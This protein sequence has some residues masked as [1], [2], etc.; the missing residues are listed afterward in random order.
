MSRARRL[1]L[2]TAAGAGLLALASPLASPRTLD[3]IH[4]ARLRR[5]GRATVPDRLAEHGAAVRARLEP[6]FAAAGVAFAPGAVLLVAFKQERRL[7]LLNSRY[8]LALRVGYPNEHDRAV[9]RAE[10]RERLGGDIMIPGGSASVGCLALGDEAAE[11]L[12]VLAALAGIEKVEVLISPVGF[13]TA[14]PPAASAGPPWVAE[15]YEGLR[16]RLRGLSSRQ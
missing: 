16:D 11:D 13:R 3:W 2:V 1:A 9:A 12:F 8:H 5:I 4:A 15:L 7:E 6:R 10:G 14:D